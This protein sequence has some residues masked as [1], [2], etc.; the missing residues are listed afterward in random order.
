[1][2]ASRSRQRKLARDKYER[3]QVRRAQ[4][5]RR[6]RQIQAAAGAFLVLALIAAGA[7]WL[8][9]WFEEDD[10]PPV[11]NEPDRCVW[12][13]LDDSAMPER[14]DVGEPPV[15]PPETGTRTMTL[16]LASGQT[17]GTVTST[18]DVAAD[19][20]AAASMEHLAAQGLFD[21][22][23]CHELTEGVALRCG[24]PG[25]TGVG[26]PTYAFYGTNVPEPP[27]EE[28]AVAYPRGTVA[29]A[30]DSG[31]HSSQFLIFFD[32]YAPDDPHWPI[33]GQV[34]EGLDVVE[35]IGAAGTAEDSTAPVEEV[36]L[37]TLSVTDPA[38]G[39]GGPSES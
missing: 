33:V 24:D 6:R 10:P 2:T 39:G 18:L 22:T 14:L 8:T 4:R 27:A 19:P 5:Q 38:A 7:V 31:Y 28:G 21:D 34:T 3:Q 23:I 11:A 30:D 35:T 12:Q 15:N 9:D 16:E 20:C 37:S 17:S 32:D 25:G 29:M 36:T 26:G 1:M 13:P